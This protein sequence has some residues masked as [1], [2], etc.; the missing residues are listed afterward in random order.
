MAFRRFALILLIAATST[1]CSGPSGE[2]P[3][4][5]VATNGGA[6]AP[7]ERKYLLERVD[8]AAVVQ[9][10]A[11]G[12]SS[13]PL[14]EKTLIW[15]LY[16][17]A[18]AGRDIY[19]DQKHRDALEM[20]GVIEQIVAHPQGVDSA[21]LREI[22]RYTKLFWINNGP[23]NNLT[24]RKFLLMLTPQQLSAAVKAASSAGA[25]FATRP[26][27]SVDQML[28]RLGPMFF[29][30]NVDPIVTNKTP[31]PGKD[32]LT[33]SANNLYSG[34]AMSD[35]KG[36]NEHY[37]LNS[38]LVKRDGRLVEEVYKIDGRYAAQ[39][40]AI[41]KHL[42]AAIP[43]ASETMAAALRALIQW[44]RTGEDADRAKYDIAWVADKNSPVDTINGFIEVYMDP[45]GIKG[46]WE[47]LVFY[48]NQDKTGR[49]RTL[50]ANAQW[51]EDR[52][53]WNPAYRKPKA[54]GI[55]ANAID[56]VVE[57]GDS[58][59][60]TPVGINLPN[61]QKIREQYGSKSISLTNVRDAYDNS[62]PSSMTSEFAWSPEESCTR[63]EI[64]SARRRAADRHAR[65]HR[66]RL[67][68]SEG[69]PGRHSAG[70][71][72]GTLF[73]PRGRARRPDRSVLPAR[74]E[75]RGARHPSR[76]RP[77]RNCPRRVRGVYAERPGS[78][79]PSPGRH[80]D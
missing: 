4:S 58:G 71:D 73:R 27:E 76:S 75:A 78:A 47:A 41:V 48:V 72:Q 20:R 29:D 30:A 23:Y 28:A 68:T 51:F 45:R 67:R 10:Y 31:G 5:R 25:T 57:T 42:E 61:D 62:T 74:S 60:V 16:Q 1:G 37:G 70:A 17:A 33:A 32:I 66:A 63:R 50:A 8:D 36:F 40:G 9:L 53:P 52:M 19:I 55:V 69:W 65:S 15:H 18:L 3:A 46:S 56:V 13:L 7:T 80:A 11:D 22:Q 12:F 44:Y 43:F 38:R 59:P 64:R 2:Q 77:G 35:L 49:I 14:R 79:S 39:I 6:T 24:A 26:G 54:T 21:T 34:V